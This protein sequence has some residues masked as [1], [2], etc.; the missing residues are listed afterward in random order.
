MLRLNAEW[1]QLLEDYKREH[2]DPRNQFCHSIGIPLI[3][4]SFPVGLSGIGLPVAAGMFV[5]GWIF[6][7]IGHYFEGNDPAFFGDSRNLLVGVI[8]FLEKK[9]LDVQKAAKAEAGARK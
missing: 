6:Q 5:T 1:T 3:A 2:A 9:G 4:G 8:W 7:F